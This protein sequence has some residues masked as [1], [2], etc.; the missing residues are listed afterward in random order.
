VISRSEEIR[1]LR[2]AGSAFE[3]LLPE[4]RDSGYLWRAATFTRFVE[5]A[6]GVWMELE[7]LGLSRELLPPLDWVIEPITRRIGRRSA[8]AY[9]DELRRAVATRKAN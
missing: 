5:D 9:L 8:A 7:T 1:E 2:H 4:G 3:S 6:L